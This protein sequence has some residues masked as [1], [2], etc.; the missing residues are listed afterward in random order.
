M[1]CISTGFVK[2]IEK[3]G[4]VSSRSFDAYKKLQKEI[5]FKRLGGMQR[6]R[7]L[8]GIGANVAFGVAPLAAGTYALAKGALGGEDYKKKYE[9][10]SR[11][12]QIRD[13]LTG[14][15]G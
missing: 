9:E 3:L 13:E 2:E 11:R 5:P 15:Q 4:K 1:N 7:V 12:N 14:A 10:L 6:A 8:A